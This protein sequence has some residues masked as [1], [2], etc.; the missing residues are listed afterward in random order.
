MTMAK[1]EISQELIEGIKSLAGESRIQ[2]LLLFV[3]GQPRT[4]NQIAG[5]VGLGQ[6]TT[7]E[8]LAQL[9]RAGMMLSERQGKEIYYR[10][11]VAYIQ[12]FLKQLS[13]TL[14]RCCRV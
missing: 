7:S 14:E 4:V 9:R 5:E 8:H 6:S 3:D 10:P 11:D 13:Q 2:I 12:R 1:V